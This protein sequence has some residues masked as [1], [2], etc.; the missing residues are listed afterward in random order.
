MRIRKLDKQD[1]T[2]IALTVLYVV[3]W[4]YIMATGIIPYGP[5]VLLP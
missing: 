1:K 4:T 3:C 2:I 5:A